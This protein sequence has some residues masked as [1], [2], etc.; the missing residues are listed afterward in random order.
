MNTQNSNKTIDLQIA[1]PKGPFVGTFD[2]T[3]KVSEVIATVRDKV[4][5]A[6]DA[7]FELWSGNTRL[8]PEHRT[9]ESFHLPNPANLKL[10]ATGEGV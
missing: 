10:V 7:Q 4:G 5:L 9:L 3:T 2:L 1:T 6:A 8:E